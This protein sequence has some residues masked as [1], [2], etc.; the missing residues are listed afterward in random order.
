MKI[1]IAMDSMKGSLSSREAGEAVEAGIR[2][3][4]PDAGIRICPLAD[5]GEGTAET[6]TTAMR[7][8]RQQVTVTGPLGEPVACGYGISQEGQ[9]RTAVMEMAAAAVRGPG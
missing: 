2:R 3:V 1:L 7:G 8:R 6:L 5:G 4:W 9:H